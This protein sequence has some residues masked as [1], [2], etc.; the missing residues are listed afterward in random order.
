[1]VYVAAYLFIGAIVATVIL[2]RSDRPKEKEI[3]YFMLISDPF[4]F[5]LPLL[6][7]PLWLAL[8][9]IPVT[10]PEEKP[11]PPAPDPK[12]MIGRTGVVVIPLAPTGRIDI[13][14]AYRDARAESGSIAAGT[15]VV[16]CAHGMGHELVARAAPAPR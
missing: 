5:W 11:M 8:L 13:E 10:L 16:V 12:N 1:M 15:P 2:V 4:L 3:G 9:A 14:G 7:W 6:L